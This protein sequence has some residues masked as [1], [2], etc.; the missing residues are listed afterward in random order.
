MA[1][2]G[3]AWEVARAFLDLAH[4]WIATPNTGIRVIPLR[5]SID[6]S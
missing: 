2:H 4:D 6:L 3:T 5:P 1:L